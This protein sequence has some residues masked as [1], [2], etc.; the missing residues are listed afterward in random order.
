VV[1]A[2]PLGAMAAEIMNRPEIASLIGEKGH[3]RCF[4]DGRTADRRMLMDD[5]MAYCHMKGTWDLYSMRA[6]NQAKLDMLP[7]F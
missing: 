3:Q 2:P 6:N 4:A 1:T 5:I 7:I